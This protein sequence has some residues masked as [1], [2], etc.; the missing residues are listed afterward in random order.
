MR[1]KRW[2]VKT[3]CMDKSRDYFE[4]GMK[5]S[6]IPFPTNSGL[7]LE[8][9]Y[10]WYGPKS[11]LADI[12]TRILRCDIPRLCF[13]HFI[14]VTWQMGTFSGSLKH[15]LLLLV[16]QHMLCSNPRGIIEST[17]LQSTLRNSG[18]DFIS[19]SAKPFWSITKQFC[20]SLFRST[21]TAQLA[22][23]LSNYLLIF[24]T[25]P[26]CVI[27]QHKERRTSILCLPLATM[28][29]LAHLYGVCAGRKC[30]FLNH[31]TE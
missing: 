7:Q 10:F 3:L 22:R 21:S 25:W 19:C 8:W 12:W 28:G 26:L 14:C 29:L 11:Q 4:F 6:C 5:Q 9:E 20:F 27:S 18:N 13:L 2:F 30:S 31:G 15:L 1:I 16:M 17:L 24:C 23:K